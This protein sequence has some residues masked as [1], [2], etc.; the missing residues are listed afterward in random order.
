MFATHVQGF[1]PYA[2]QL[3]VAAAMCKVSPV[4]VM[5]WVWYCYLTLIMSLVLVFTN[6]P[7]AKNLKKD[8][9]DNFENLSDD[10]SL[11]DSAKD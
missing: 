10:G 5:P 11:L 2:G 7:K 9:Y 4:D 1:I 6:F 8:G 3:L